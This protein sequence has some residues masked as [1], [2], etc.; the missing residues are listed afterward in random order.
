MHQKQVR[1]Y[2]YIYTATQN[3]KV[4]GMLNQILK[5]GDAKSGIKFYKYLLVSFFLFVLF[6]KLRSII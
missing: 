4:G 2:I 1:I 6:I 3:K 5:V